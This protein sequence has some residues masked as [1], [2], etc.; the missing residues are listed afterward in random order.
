MPFESSGTSDNY[1]S[2]STGLSSESGR[3]GAFRGFAN[4]EIDRVLGRL[5]RLL[6]AKDYS[7][8]EAHLKFWLGEAGAAG[9]RAARLTLL[10]ELMGFYRRGGDGTAAWQFAEAALEE[11]GS[12]NEFCGTVFFG[13]TCLNAATVFKAFGA[14]ERALGLYERCMEI[15]REQLEPDDVRFG[16]LYNNMGLALHELGRFSEAREAFEA[17]IRVQE[18][19][20]AATALDRAITY[21]N[22]CDLAVSIDAADGEGRDP[23]GISGSDPGYSVS[24]STAE[25]ID[26]LI[27]KAYGLIID[28]EVPRNPYYAFVCEKC[29]PVF[30]FYGYFLYKNELADAA[31]ALDA[32]FGAK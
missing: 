14:P 31:K 20:G 19:G 10:N 12:D 30:G 4:F 1:Y 26:R 16:G 25:E 7:A 28:P 23:V 2:E 11:Y 18:D 29:A 13:T 15:Y 21:L 17:A 9:D 8:A 24:D 27:E 6:A 32:Q 3:G 5:D 22:L